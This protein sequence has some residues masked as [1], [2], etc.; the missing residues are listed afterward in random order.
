M[1]DANH[2]YYK[3]IADIIEQYRNGC[4]SGE[5]AILIIDFLNTE[6]ISV[7]KMKDKIEELEVENGFESRNYW[8]CQ[9]RIIQVLKELLP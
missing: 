3:P 1:T 7:E 6:T 5:I 2:P 8:R 9:E 4:S